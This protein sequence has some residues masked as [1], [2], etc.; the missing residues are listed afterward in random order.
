MT[1]GTKTAE[2]AGRRRLRLVR[3]RPE[4]T[5]TQTLG[6]MAQH[7][8]TMLGLDPARARWL[9]VRMGRTRKPAA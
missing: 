2:T 4:T 3:L 7:L 8:S 1:E 5:S 9:L 6:T